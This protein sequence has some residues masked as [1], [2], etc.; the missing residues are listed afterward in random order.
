MDRAT[1]L[2]PVAGCLPLLVS[3]H[4]LQGVPD[5]VVHL[6]SRKLV[7]AVPRT[8]SCGVDPGGDVLWTPL[9]GADDGT[10]GWMVGPG[11]GVRR[12]AAGS[13]T[14][15]PQQLTDDPRVAHGPARP[16]LER[17]WD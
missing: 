7:R 4:H 16:W 14:V 13:G 8:Q 9:A 15:E 5:A 10:G 1:W 17:A 6:C 3:F 11:D 2:R 12:I